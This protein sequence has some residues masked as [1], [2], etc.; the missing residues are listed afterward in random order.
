MLLVNLWQLALLV[1]APVVATGLTII[2][3]KLVAQRPR[4]LNKMGH[5]ELDFFPFDLTAGFTSMPSGHTATVVC[6]A[7]VLGVIIP[8]VKIAVFFGV[9]FIAFSRLAL[10]NHYFADLVFG[11]AIAVAI[12]VPYLQFFACRRMGIRQTETGRL[13]LKPVWRTLLN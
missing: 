1:L 9:A 8:R 11:A 5:G 13:T 4:P 6:G 7:I 12:T 3:L 2:L 10:M